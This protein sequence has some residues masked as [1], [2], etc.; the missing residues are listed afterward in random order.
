MKWK[1]ALYD[2]LSLVILDGYLR[3][4][5]DLAGRLPGILAIEECFR[6]CVMGCDVAGRMRCRSE[7]LRLP[8]PQ[9]ISSILRRTGLPITVAEVD[10]L[11]LVAAV[12]YEVPVVTGDERFEASLKR[13]AVPASQLSTLIGRPRRSGVG[14]PG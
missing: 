4:D 11:T 3:D 10:A 12:H 7:F 2:A 14:A 8:G 9:V 5:A 6:P 13:A 1:T